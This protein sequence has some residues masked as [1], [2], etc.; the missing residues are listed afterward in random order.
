MPKSANEP[1]LEVADFIANAVGGHARHTLVQ[2]RDGFRK[3]F[4]TIFQR[5]DRRLASFIAIE[6]VE[7]TPGRQR[8]S[9]IEKSAFNGRDILEDLHP[10]ASRTE[11]GR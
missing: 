2:K 8:G 7:L 6:R 1:A 4:T 5:I 11:I 3:D 10:E 9:A